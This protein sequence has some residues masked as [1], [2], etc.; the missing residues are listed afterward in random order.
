MA[1]RA[2]KNLCTFAE[3]NKIPAASQLFFNHST[4]LLEEDPILPTHPAIYSWSAI[5]EAQY[6][7]LHERALLVVDTVAL[8]GNKYDINWELLGSSAIA[9]AVVLCHNA[10]FY[11]ALEGKILSNFN[12]AHT[13]FH[14]TKNYAEVTSTIAAS[15]KQ[16][17]FECSPCPISLAY[18]G[19]SVNNTMETLC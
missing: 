8:G 18:S 1:S 10:H 11:V 15:Y 16:K 17:R 19:G 5:F 4:K 3:L 7:S 12:A 9:P 6:A 2:Y 13:K 14:A